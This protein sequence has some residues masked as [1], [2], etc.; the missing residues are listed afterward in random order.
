MKLS[1]K[2]IHKSFGDVQAL[3]AVTL[4]LAAGEVHAICG[5]NGAGK[6]TLMNILSGNLQPDSGEIWVDNQRETIQNQ[7]KATALGIAIVHQHLSLFE[8]QTIA[9]N[10]FVNQ[11]PTN[12]WGLIDFKKLNDDTQN[13][14][15]KLNL[16]HTLQP[17]V[18]VSALSIAQ[19]QL[20]EIAKALAKKPSILILDEPTASISEID[21]Q[22]LFGV[23]RELQS[24]GTAVVYISH[25]LEEIFEIADRVSI[26]KDGKYVDTLPTQRLQKEQLVA[27]MVGRDIPK[28]EKIQHK[29]RKVCLEV[30]GLS[31]N[32]LKNISFKIHQGEIVALAGLVGAG[33]S[34]IA[35][36]IFGFLAHQIAQI[37][38]NGTPLSI[39]SPKDAIQNGIAYVPENRKELGLFVEKSIADNISAIDSKPFFYDAQ[40]AVQTADF[41][42]SELRIVATH[43]AQK[44]SSLSGGNQQKVVLAKWLSQ[45]PTLLIIDEPTH[46][47]DVGAKFEIYELLKKF[48]ST[49]KSILL[50]SS[51]LKEVM[52]LSD[53][54]L[55]IKNGE[56]V[57]EFYTEHTTEEEVLA[58][59]I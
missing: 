9:E 49:G 15:E 36:S 32:F 44:V 58:S 45:D 18:K 40:M 10:I 27:L 54:I 43:T 35:Q 47:I 56:I 22:L 59:A 50:I 42:Q 1:L 52:M 5:E 34:E 4:D 11:F 33:R 26:L 41:Y 31:S 16:G 55:V 39:A 38:L 46:G 24:H 37:T 17:N 53:R 2:N 21:T 57:N 19:K 3:Q 28:F 13:L 25:R 29:Q 7:Q 8:H 14:L 20:V 30:R 12:R 6:S 48:V 51:E 23:I